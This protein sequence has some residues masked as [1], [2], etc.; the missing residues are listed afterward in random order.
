VDTNVLIDI[1][2]IFTGQIN[3]RTNR[4]Y[5]NY[6]DFIDLIGDRTIEVLVVP[7]VLEEIR[8]G[9]HKDDYMLETFIM[10]MCEQCEFTD[11]ELELV[12]ML[13][14]DYIEGEESAI[15]VF[16][17]MGD[18]LKYNAKDAR[19]LAEIIVLYN[20][21]K[22][23]AIKFITNNIQDFINID[24]IKEINAKYNLKMIPFNSMKA[25]NVKKE[26]R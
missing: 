2:K 18:H 24:A 11:K 19:I 14:R 23:D 12:D 26:I 20:S 6:T 15:P 1:M 8:R 16:K 5:Q 21:K 4:Y 13:Y 9:S 3:P 17:D 7:T 25:S 22:Y 10:R